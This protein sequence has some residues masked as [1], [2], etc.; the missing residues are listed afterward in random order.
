MLHRKDLEI[1]TLTDQV[2][3]KVSLE[4]KIRSMESKLASSREIVRELE[5]AKRQIKDL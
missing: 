4:E 2:H 1:E 5:E 3:K